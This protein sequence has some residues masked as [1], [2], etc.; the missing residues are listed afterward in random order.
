M[1]DDRPVPRK[2]VQPFEQVPERDRDASLH[3]ELLALGF[4]PH[5]EHERRIGPR[6]LLVERRAVIRSIRSTSSGRRS[7]AIIPPS[8]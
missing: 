6:E 4:G 8:R 7:S 1:D 5:V 3:G 2:L